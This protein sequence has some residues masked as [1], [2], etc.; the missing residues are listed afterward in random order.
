MYDY[1]PMTLNEL[2]N[3]FE[4]IFGEYSCEY[5][6]GK[7]D[8]SRSETNCSSISS[9]VIKNDSTEAVVEIVL[10][11]YKK[12]EISVKVVGKYLVV[13]VDG[14]RGKKSVKRAITETADVDKISAKFENGILT[15]TIPVKPAT[16]IKIS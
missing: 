1:K 13:S 15:V 9:T 5:P 4:T 16:E 2:M 6:E 12:E 3:S 7:C 10:P 14:V 11:G 8:C